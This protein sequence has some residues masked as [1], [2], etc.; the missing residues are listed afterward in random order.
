M[1]KDPE[2]PKQ[3][4]REK[5]KKKKKAGGI[6]FPWLQTIL[7]SYSYQNSIALA[8]R[9]RHIGQWNGIETSYIIPSPI[10]NLQRKE[11][12]YMME[13]DRLFYQC[14]LHTHT[15]HAPIVNIQQRKQG[16]TMQKRQILLSSAEKTGQSYIE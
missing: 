11:Q 6:T 3:S 12:G 4:W 16:Y 14:F 9:N 13:K 15:P 1:T 7:Q 8:P 5:K 10:I 2:L